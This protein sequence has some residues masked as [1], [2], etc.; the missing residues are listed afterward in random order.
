MMHGYGFGM[1]DWMT[2]SGMLFNGTGWMVMPMMGIGLLLIVGLIAWL[3]WSQ[4]GS[5]SLDGPQIG[6][7]Q[8][9]PGGHFGNSPMASSSAEPVEQIARRRYARGEIDAIEYQ[10]I[11]ATLRGQ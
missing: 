3:I 11:V 8:T 9:M 5:L 10:T 7:Q 1:D 6:G 2:S 4:R